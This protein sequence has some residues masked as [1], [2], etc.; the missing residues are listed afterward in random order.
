M[1][2]G[3]MRGEQTKLNR[4]DMTRQQKIQEKM[5]GDARRGEKK[6]GDEIAI[7]E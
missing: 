5:R 7:L 4:R 3:K 6:R 2:R 1:R